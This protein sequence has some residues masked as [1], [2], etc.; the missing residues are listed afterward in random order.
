MRHRRRSCLVYG[1]AM[2]GVVMSYVGLS[3][4]AL[5]A[6]RLYKLH[7]VLLVLLVHRVVIGLPIAFSVRFA[8]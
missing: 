8:R 2:W 7:D 5:H 1:L 4:S 6:R 3:L